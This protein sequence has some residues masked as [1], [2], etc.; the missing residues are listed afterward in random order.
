MEN[1]PYP[2]PD[3]EELR[4]EAL[5]SYG[6]V[7]SEYDESFDILTELAKD[8]TDCPIALITLLEKD[9]QWFKSHAGLE[10]R[11]T[12]REESFCTYA[13]L[14]PEK[15]LIVEDA[16]VDDRFKDLPTVI[17][18]PKLRSYLGI[19]LVTGDG[20]ALGSLCVLDFKT[21]DFSD[22]TIRRMQIL[23]QLC[24]QNIESYRNKRFIEDLLTDLDGQNERLN[25]FAA[26]AA[27]D[28][29]G[30]VRSIQQLVGL[31]ESKYQE[32]E[33]KKVAKIMKMIKDQAK[34]AVEVV[35]ETLGLARSLK[36]VTTNMSEKVVL[37]KVLAEIESILG[38]QY[39][40]PFKVILRDKEFE[41]IANR[42]AVKRIVLNIFSNSIKHN[43]KEEVLIEMTPT[44]SKGEIQLQIDDNG[45][46]ISRHLRSKLFEMYKTAR[47]SKSKSGIG[48]YTV[49]ELVESMGG[50]V[51][52]STN[53]IQ[54]A[55]FTVSIPKKA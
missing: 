7:D 3:N 13:I 19:P 49:K 23:A 55:R 50:E 37:K 5:E 42:L 2:K 26:K 45:P 16:S 40:R 32:G 46:G 54:G 22:K 34:G 6:I 4:L 38:H 41:F 18:S 8:I 53:S 30:P 1:P 28:L 14:K 11:E 29:K 47:G 44:E 9:R 17:N 43:D 33:D 39:N 15:P 31:M 48:L 35:D 21:K 10:I 51:K 24:M 36:A 27:H 52:I 20:F 25:H 12:K